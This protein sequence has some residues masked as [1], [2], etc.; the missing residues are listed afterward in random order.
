R[1]QRIKAGRDSD[2]APDAIRTHHQPQD[3]QGA[4]PDDPAVPAWTGGSGDRIVERRT[5]MGLLAGGLL[6]APLAAEAQS[7]KKVYRIGFL[8]A[9]SPFQQVHYFEKFV[10]GLVDLGYVES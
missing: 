1:P 2:R 7:A 6:A 3:R 8:G 5:F 10:Q 4:R 9:G